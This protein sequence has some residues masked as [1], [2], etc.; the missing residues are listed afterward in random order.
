MGQQIL[1]SK[2]AAKVK[3]VQAAQESIREAHQDARK[4]F[5]G[6]NDEA[7]IKAIHTA[8]KKHGTIY[9]NALLIA[10]LYI[11]ND[12]G[13]YWRKAKVSPS[14][15]SQAAISLKDVGIKGTSSYSSQSE[16]E[17]GLRRALSWMYTPLIAIPHI[18]QVANIFLDNSMKDVA[19]GVSEYFGSTT[20]DKFRADLIKSGA[21]FDEI[22][23][24]MMDDAAGGGLVR[25]MFHH[26][27][28][29][30]VR[31]QEIGIAAAS[32]KHAALD[33]AGTL[34][35]NSSDKWARYTL[36]KLGINPDHLA[37][38][39]FKLTEDQIRKAMYSEAN[40]T[41]FIR[42]QL[43]TPWRWEESFVARMGS[44]YR[45]F[46][47]RQTQFLAEVFK[48][49]LK[50][51]GPTQFLKTVA[52]FGTLFPAFGELVH[53]MENMALL[54]SPTERDPK[55]KL[56]DN[57]YVDAMAHAAGFGV[58][59]SMTRAGLFNGGRGYLEGP[60][61]STADDILIG[62]PTRLVKGT[63]YLAKGD[64]DKA[65]KQFK[66]AVRAVAGKLGA[67]GRAAAEFLK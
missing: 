64:R 51:G 60:L 45:H 19:K 7:L 26:P 47:Y 65:K 36:A 39:G 50:E 15:S 34:S 10:C 23:Y 48:N 55:R 49:S 18:G 2:I 37:E 22:R 1:E 24:Q 33:A 46:Q 29:N 40:R 62:I 35:T 27:G 44:Q 3:P 5:L 12:A 28:F 13:S 53:S 58:F 42:S 8:T 66:G 52:T 67:P 38:Q 9:G 63:K 32:G 16:I 31:R 4:I 57:E 43:K 41:I 54:K 17:G 11:F 6:Q 61:F 59:Y 20:K 21:L 14:G 30:F 56:L 25:K